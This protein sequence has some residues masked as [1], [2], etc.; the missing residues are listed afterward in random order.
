M[1]KVSWNTVNKKQNGL[2]QI[3]NEKYKSLAIELEPNFHGV[4]TPQSSEWI[5]YIISYAYNPFTAP[6]G[7]LSGQARRQF[8]VYD[9][10]RIAAHLVYM[11]LVF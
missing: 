5:I 2:E 9:A 11:P 1:E 8:C 7:G 4:A 6:L 10:D 3:E